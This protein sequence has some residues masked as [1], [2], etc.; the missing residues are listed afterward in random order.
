MLRKIGIVALLSL[1]A[2]LGGMV[3]LWILGH[4]HLAI[5]GFLLCPVLIILYP[6]FDRLPG[7]NETV[8]IVIV[9]TSNAFTFLVLTL[10]LI[11]LIRRIVFS[12]SK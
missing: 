4:E 6:I 11:R 3:A 10:Y 8:V 7:L 5:D 12:G 9:A 2:V 1:S